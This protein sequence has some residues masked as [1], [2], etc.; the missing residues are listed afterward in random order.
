MPV[1]RA[2]GE[3]EQEIVFEFQMAI[4]AVVTTMI[5]DVV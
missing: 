4:T 1:A 5:V 3:A 2:L